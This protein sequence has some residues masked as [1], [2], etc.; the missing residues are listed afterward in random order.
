MKNFV[1]TIC[2]CLA[3]LGSRAAYVQI[4]NTSGTS[5]YGSLSATVTSTGSI[6]TWTSW[7]TTSFG[8]SYWAGSGTAGSYTFTLSHPVASLKIP[9][10]ALNG[11]P[12]GS[13]EYLQMYINGVFYPLTAANMTSYTDCGSGA[14]PCYLFGGLLMGPSGS[15]VDY[16]G[17][18]FIINSCTGINS[19]EVYCNGILNGVTFYVFVDTTFSCFNAVNNGPLCTGDSL[20]LAAVGGDST[21]PYVWHGAGGFTSTGITANIA[22]VTQADSGVYYVVQTIGG[23]NDTAFTHVVINPK[24]T[25][26]AANNSPLCPASGLP[27]DLTSTPFVTGETFSW[28]GPSGYTSAVQNPVITAFTAADTGMFRVIVDL[29]GCYDT[30]YTHVSLN[31]FTAINDG[32]VCFGDTLKLIAQDGD[33]TQPFTWYGP[34]GGVLGTGEYLTINAT[35]WAD[36]GN[37]YVVQVIGGLHDTARTHVVIKP[38]PVVTANSNSPICAN[39]GNVL[40][41]YST[42]ASTGETFSWIGPNGFTSTLENPNITNFPGAD[43]GWYKVY[44]FLNGC[45]DSAETYVKQTPTPPAPTITGYSPYCFGATFIPFVVTGVT[46]GVINWYNVGTGGTPGSVPLTVNTSVAGNTTVWVSQSVAGCEGPRDSASVTVLPDIIPSFTYAIHR[47]C[48]YDTVFFNNTSTGADY[49][50]WNFGDMTGN[51]SFS[52]THLY[53]ATYPYTVPNCFAGVVTLV[54]SNGYCGKTVTADINTS[55]PLTAN[56]APIPDTICLGGSTTLTDASIGGGLTYAWTLGDGNTS[57][58]AG[59]VTHTYNIPGIIITQLD[60]T[61][62]ISCHDSKTVKLF[63]LD[64]AI[65]SFHDTTFCQT[66]PLALYNTVR[67][68]MGTFEYTHNWSPAGNLT[69][70][71]AAVPFFSGFGDFQLVLTDT[72]QPFGCLAYDTIN[73]HSILGNKITNMTSATSIRLGA[74]VQLNADNEMT[75]YWLPDN[76]TLS[77]PNINNPVATPSVTTTYV[78]YGRDNF[79]CLDSTTVQITVDSTVVQMFP[80]GFTP[81]GD[82]LNDVF[83]PIGLTFQNM[84]EMRIFNRWGQQIFYTN[85]KQTGW[86]GTFNGVPQEMG[87]YFY[88]CVIQKPGQEQNEVVTGEVTLIR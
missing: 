70:D 17:G 72:L 62:S 8:T 16:N 79:G 31:C 44:T 47:G 59:S 22:N 19:F 38:L 54:D 35:S 10:Y 52:P 32:P 75:Y 41:L 65:T 67:S 81:N 61:D 7:C 88:E 1:L 76:G 64:F 83:R 63:V 73:I 71:T 69:S 14:G 2:A 74:S 36:S 60:I 5:T 48:S 50:H 39:P 13:G 45:K 33:S 30:A 80:S 53:T 51:Y 42:P 28:T 49:Y 66:M 4:T 86:D 24:P 3:F 15:D 21:L 23:V 29:N 6:T 46:A 56:Y 9:S 82:G 25:I 43:T 77:N 68:N 84:V 87:T 20:K 34:S 57:T 26:S 37:V 58:T 40:D 27:L 11:G 78:V 85:S 18:D 12:F 55:H